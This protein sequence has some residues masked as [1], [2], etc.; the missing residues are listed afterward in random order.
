MARLHTRGWEVQSL[1]AG[2]EFDTITGSPTINTTTKRTGA[3]AMRCNPSAATAYVQSDYADETTIH[4]GRVYIYIAS[5][6]AALTDIFIF[7]DNANSYTARIRLATDRTLELWSDSAKVGSS[8]SAIP[9]NEW[10]AVELSYDDSVANNT[11]VGRLDFVQFATGNGGDNGGNGRFRCGI[12]TSTTADVYFDDLA[13]NN[14]TGSSETSWPAEGK[15]FRMN[16]NNSG[17][18]NSFATQTG[19][20]AGSANNYTRINETTPDDATTFNGSST[21]NEEDMVNFDPS[22]INPGDIVK[23]VEVWFRFRN[24]TADATAKITLNIEKT[25]SGTRSSSA[26]ITPNSTTWKT[27]TT[28][29]PRNAPIVLY[30]DPDGSKWLQET[31]DTLQA[32]YKLTT[33]P[34]TAG[35]RIDVSWLMVLVEYSP[36][37]GIVTFNRN[38]R[39]AMAANLVR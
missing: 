24:S 32:G 30:N 21:L 13:I 35:R 20:T 22:G 5:A 6:P 34:G 23:V 37:R 19:G 18:A 10:H 28:A 38:R 17:D 8:S 4:L 3:A 33:A 27:N 12:I 29:V 15:I 1:T 7:G 16:P 26:A 25:G 14:S 9:L 36:G 39:S 31:L 11:I 2:L